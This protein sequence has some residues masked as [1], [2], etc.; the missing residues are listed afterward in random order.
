VSEQVSGQLPEGG[1]QLSAAEVDALDLRWSSCWT[2]EMGAKCLAGVPARWCVA[3]SWAL[4]L[5][6]GEQTRVHSDLEIA[7]PAA[8][9]PLIR[10]RFS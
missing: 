4:D 8:D 2:P 9:F 1:V 3:G 7:L 10:A 5:F 6:R